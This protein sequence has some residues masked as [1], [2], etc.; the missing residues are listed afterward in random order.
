MTKDVPRFEAKLFLMNLSTN[1][2]TLFFIVKG[3]SKKISKKLAALKMTYLCFK[4]IHANW[5]KVNPEMY[6]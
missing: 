5:K 4:D 1:E 3:R 6:E 2:N